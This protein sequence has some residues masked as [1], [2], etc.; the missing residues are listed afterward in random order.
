MI[1]IVLVNWNA[2]YQLRDVI[3][4]IARFHSN[5]VDTVIIVDNAST[6]DSVVHVESLAL[7]APFSLQMIQ[8][9]ENRGFGAACNQGA[10]Q[11]ASEYLLFL[12]PD[13]VLYEDTLIKVAAYMQS[14][15]NDKVGICGVQLIDETGH[16]NVCTNIPL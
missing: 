16:M 12:N 11:S 13:A 4:S 3:L 10:K 8:N 15:E 9:S 7:D 1:S 5:L 14:P 2:G 6:D